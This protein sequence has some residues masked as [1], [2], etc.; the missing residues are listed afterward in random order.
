MN[1]RACVQGVDCVYPI[2]WGEHDFSVFFSVY[3]DLEDKWCQF[4]RTRV[5][6]DTK[7]GSWKCLCRLKRSRCVHKC[8]S[9]WWLFQERPELLQNGLHVHTDQAGALEEALTDAEDAV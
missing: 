8:L 1:S 2:F 5:S 6:F 4:G 9:L 3:T 7:S